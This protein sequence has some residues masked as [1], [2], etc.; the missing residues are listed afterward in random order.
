MNQIKKDLE[1]ELQSMALSDKKKQLIVEKIKSS[2]MRSKRGSSWSYRLVLMTFTFFMVSF[3]YLL[4]QQGGTV[5]EESNAAESSKSL[6]HGSLFL[7]SDWMKGIILMGI[8]IGVRL[9]VGKYLE[10]KGRG[11]P[12][13]V[14]CGE[15]WPTREARKM[16]MKNGVVTCPN[17]GK[18]QYKT[19]K[20][21]QIASSLNVL[22]PFGIITSQ[23]FSHTLLGFLIHAVGSAWLIFVLTPFIIELQ[24]ED[25]IIKP[26]Y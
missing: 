13:C 8:F 12:A 4:L 11:L 26:L 19:R 21:T 17:C 5:K 16:G 25:P 23:L 15:E 7:T 2:E 22:L 3:G 18:K 10:R 24:E 6:S 9:L 14:E 20:S 1:K